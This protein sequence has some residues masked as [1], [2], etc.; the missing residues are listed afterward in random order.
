M[1]GKDTTHVVA[2]VNM[3]TYHGSHPFIGS[4]FRLEL[5]LGS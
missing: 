5:N 4:T 1:N 3:H 2:I